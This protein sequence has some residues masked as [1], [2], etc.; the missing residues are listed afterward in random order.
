MRRG[1]NSRPGA[2]KDRRRCRHR[3]LPPHPAPELP[4]TRYWRADSDCM[5]N[6]GYIVR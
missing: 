1:A 5:Q 3:A 2:L 4:M 6:R